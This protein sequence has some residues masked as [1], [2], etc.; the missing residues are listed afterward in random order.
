MKQRVAAAIDEAAS[1]LEEV[2]RDIEREPELGF[3]EH[4]TAAK[5]ER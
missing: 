2:A 3:K 1:V 4:K 5:V